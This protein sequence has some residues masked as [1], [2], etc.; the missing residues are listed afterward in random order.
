[1][2]INTSNEKKIDYNVFR[3]IEDKLSNFIKLC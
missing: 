1:M 3:N 2:S